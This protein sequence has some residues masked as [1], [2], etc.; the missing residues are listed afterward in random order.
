[1]KLQLFVNN[2][3]Q[4]IMYIECVSASLIKH[5]LPSIATKITID[6]VR[7]M[8]RIYIMEYFG[9][10]DTHTRVCVRACARVLH[11]WITLILMVSGVD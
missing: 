8:V 2:D 9:F 4:S 10:L 11:S 1:M 6:R 7:F 3:I 5:F